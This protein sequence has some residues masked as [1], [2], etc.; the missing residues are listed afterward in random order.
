MKA[1]CAALVASALLITTPAAAGSFC[2][3]IP[4][5]GQCLLIARDGSGATTVV[6]TT[7]S[8][9]EPQLGESA[10][11]SAPASTDSAAK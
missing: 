5:T 3:Q 1:L 2:F 9:I 7:L 11:A 4:S 8:A 6:P 10:G